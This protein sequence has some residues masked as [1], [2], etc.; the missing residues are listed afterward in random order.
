MSPL[1]SP[2]DDAD[3]QDF[4]ECEN[5]HDD[6]WNTFTSY[7]EENHH[8]VFLL[9]RQ[10]RRRRSVKVKKEK[11]KKY[12][13]IGTTDNSK[14]RSLLCTVA[15]C[16]RFVKKGRKCLQHRKQI[17]R[18]DEHFAKRSSPSHNVGFYDEA[19]CD[20]GSSDN[21]NESITI[22][23]VDSQ[24]GAL[25]QYYKVN[26]HSSLSNIC[27]I[28]SRRRGIPI[29]M[30]EF[31]C[32]EDIQLKFGDEM[33]QI[34]V[35]IWLTNDVNPK[36]ITIDVEPSDTID[37]IKNKIQNKVWLS[38]GICTSSEHCLVVSGTETKIEN[39]V[40]K[41]SSTSKRCLVFA[42]TELEDEY[43]LSDY[44]IQR[45]QNH[46]FYLIPRRLLGEN[47][48]DNQI[49]DSPA[50]L[51]MKG[52]VVTISVI[53]STPPKMPLELEPEAE[54]EN[55]NEIAIEIKDAISLDHFET[56][57]MEND[58]TDG[59][60]WLFERYASL[61]K[62]KI[63][64]VR[65]KYKERPLFLSNVKNKS[66]SDLGMQHN[67]VI[68]AWYITDRILE[69]SNSSKVHSASEKKQSRCKVRTPKR[70]TKA[71]G[72]NSASPKKLPYHDI[73]NEKKWKRLHSRA[74]SRVFEEAATIFKEI[75]QKLDAL[76]LERTKPKS[77]RNNI[78]NNVTTATTPID[79]PSNEG[80]GGKAGKTHYAIHVGEVSNL[81]KSSKKHSKQR[82]HNKTRRNITSANITVD[83]HG[84]TVVEAESKLNECLPVWMK[85][86]MHGS[87]PFVT[88]VTIICGAGSQILSEVVEN[89]I[90]Q[91]EKV[92]NAPKK[93]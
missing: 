84:M 50:S 24:G 25:P 7:Y 71:R 4:C 91:N 76:N 48:C 72:K 59:P 52:A 85:I 69:T 40:G 60:K 26:K 41:H 88:R 35:K 56:L 23:M 53:N 9:Q 46:T 8:D 89:W 45:Y 90:K 81:Y 55:D 49:N 19:I 6:E 73:D 5:H 21:E 51:D 37:K 62:T 68:Y 82:K 75:R 47:C 79:N 67:D 80:L 58:D 10:Q 92:S 16:N 30:L 22:K 29:R 43:T 32:N 28:Y 42:M 34:I 93:S 44:N 31:R 54:E 77:K 18:K 66:A 83:L 61:V 63:K 12:T 86:A 78:K 33:N 27:R 1:S 20:D 36:T 39:K 2:N 15:G 38:T 3:T 87:Y 17:K 57:T 65:F 64:F 14:E 74:I 70:G 11:K 13:K